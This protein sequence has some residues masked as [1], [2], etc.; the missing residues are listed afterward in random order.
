MIDSIEN[1]TVNYIAKCNCY[2]WVNASMYYID[3]YNIKHEI[4]VANNMNNTTWKK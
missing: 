4:T 3:E 2:K 1:N